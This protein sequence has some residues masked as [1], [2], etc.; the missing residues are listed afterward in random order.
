MSHNH[1]G[2]IYLEDA[3]IIA[4]HHW[5]DDQHIL[6]LS[7][8]QCSR[9]AQAGQFVHLQCDESLPLRRPLSIMQSDPN[10]GWI[11]LLYK[12]VGHGTS[13]LAK[14]KT[15]ESLNLLGPIGNTFTLNKDRPH[16]LLIGG[17]VGIPPM[18]FLASHIADQQPDNTHNTLVLMGSESVFPFD[19]STAANAVDGIQADCN[20]SL[21]TIDTF[22][23]SSR[24]ASLQNFTG[25]Y[26]GYVTEL[27][28]SHCETL[29]QSILNQTEIFACGPY[30]MLKSVQLLA[31]SFRIPCQVSLEETMAC[32]V[33]GCAGCT[34]QLTTG[35]GA[36]MKRV[37]V[38]GPVFD[39][40]S[41]NF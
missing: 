8:K 30:P 41:I 14:R 40:D 11:D 36:V 37:C 23:I 19:L 10:K 27:A 21:S 1:R 39:A 17:G 13:L 6:R 29:D 5:P 26:Q 4:H 32:G 9:T 31:N 34:V 25:C 15:G 12:V 18:V 7:A 24:L 22:N 38:D 3:E 35:N 28:K 2:S 20:A 33:G 16:R